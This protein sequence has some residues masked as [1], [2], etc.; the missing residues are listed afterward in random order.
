MIDFRARIHAFFKKH[1]KKVIIFALVAWLIIFIINLILKYRTPKVPEPSTTYTPHVP[2]YSEDEEAQVPEKYQK[3]IEDLVDKYFNYCNNGEYENAYN[4]ITEDCRNKLYPTLDQFKGYVDFVFQGKKKIYNIQNYSIVDNKYVYNIR[5]LD[6]IMANGTTDGYYYYEEKLILIEENGEIK[7][8][9]GEYVGDENPNIYVEDDNMIVEIT[10]KSVEYE[11]ETYTVKITNKTDKYI[12][13]ADNTQNDEVV[14]DLGGSV[15][16]P[17]N[18]TIVSYYA[19]P[20]STSTYDFKF[21][22]FY[23]NGLKSQKL[24]LNSIRILNEYNPRTGTTQEDLDGAVKL[25]GIQIDL[26]K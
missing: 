18:T 12:V 24:I 6:D 23:D 20:G 19:N 15:R 14:L 16:H 3:P 1:K 13:I 7:L 8:S 22:K 11:T 2:I 17:V 10:N 5:I 4:L 9:I 26:N 25:Y 21:N